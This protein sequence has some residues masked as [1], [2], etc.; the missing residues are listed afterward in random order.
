MVSNAVTG[1]LPDSLGSS[2]LSSIAAGAA[3]AA[4]GGALGSTGGAMSGANGALGADLYNRQLHPDERKWAKD[5]ASKFA[6][7]YEENTGQSITADQAQQMLL[8]NGYRLVDSDASKEP[9]GNAVAVAFISANAGNMFTATPNEYKNPDLYGNADH[10]LTPEQKAFPASAANPAAGAAIVGGLAPELLAGGSAATAYAQEFLA[11]YKAAQAG[12][13]LT[14]AAGTGAAVSG[15]IYTGTA[16]LGA[17]I[18]N[19]LHG[20]PYA[21]AFANRFSGV[22]FAAAA[23]FGA[24]AN[25]FTT[26]MFNWVGVPNSLQNAATIPGIVIRGIKLAL[27]QSA[28]KAVQAAVNADGSK[29]K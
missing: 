7:F 9:G 24:Y 3:G 14:T 13:S 11:A 19:Y 27:G 12:Y 4:A 20:T 6:Q 2:I 15:G 22:G 10:S 1:A 21:D 26:Q 28:G 8:A 23:T 29:N 16:G 25:I 5:N 17:A 18:D